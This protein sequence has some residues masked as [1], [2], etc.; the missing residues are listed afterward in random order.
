MSSLEAFIFSL[1][2]KANLEDVNKAHYKPFLYQEYSTS[3]LLLRCDGVQLHAKRP[4]YP[5]AE[6]S[7]SW[8]ALDTQFKQTWLDS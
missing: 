3:L 6:I 8:P 7:T 5:A 4:N 2:S 1:Y